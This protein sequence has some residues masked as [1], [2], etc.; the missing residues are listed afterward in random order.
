M[1]IFKY[2]SV[3][4]CFRNFKASP[5]DG[6]SPFFFT[7]WKMTSSLCFF[8]LIKDDL[9]SVF[10]SIK[11]DFLSLFSTWGKTTS[12]FFTWWRTTL[13]IFTWWKAT[14]SLCFYLIKDD[15]LS[16]FFTW[17]K[18]TSSLC[19]LLDKRR[20]P[21]SVFYLMKNDLL[22]VFYL[23]EDDLLSRFYLMKDDLLSLFFTWWKRTSSLWMGN[24]RG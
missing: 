23:M 6:C 20:P 14:S 5:L 2:L 9:L 10:Y 19:F 12:L 15:L 1:I 3:D 21:L 13:L 8:Y 17:W 18:T 16:L 22:S 7:W 4:F 11:V 24:L